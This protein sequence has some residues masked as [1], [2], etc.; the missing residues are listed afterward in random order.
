MP[1]KDSGPT[2]SLD[3]PDRLAITGSAPDKIAEAA[4]DLTL[5]YW[6]NA[7]DSAARRVGLV[8]QPSGKAG[9]K[10]DLE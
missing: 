9:V 5:R 2:V 1:T 8:E 6:K 4:M 7:R 3:G 10:T